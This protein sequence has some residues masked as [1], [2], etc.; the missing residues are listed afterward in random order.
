M[1]LFVFLLL[2]GLCWFL[3]EYAVSAPKW[4]GSAGSS[5]VHAGTVGYGSVTDRAGE[6]LLEIG[7]SKAYSTDA[8]TLSVILAVSS[9]F[10]YVSVLDPI[11]F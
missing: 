8:S 10:L 9:A 1:G 5:Y 7:D 4:I 3:F 11:Y 2:G 6:S